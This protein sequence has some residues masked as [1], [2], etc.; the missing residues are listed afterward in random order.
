M[1][2]GKSFGRALRR[3]RAFFG[4]DRANVAMIFGLSLV[5]LTLAA[6]AGLDM[7][8]AMIVKSNLTEAV[9]AAALAVASTSTKTTMTQADMELEAKQYFWANYTLNTT[10]YGAPPIQPTVTPGTQSVTVTSTVNVPT[11]LMR[12]AKELGVTKWPYVTVNATST[13]V[14][15]QTKLWVSLVLDNTGSMTQTDGTGTSKISALQTATHQLLTMLQNASAKRRAEHECRSGIELPVDHFVQ[16][17]PLHHGRDERLVQHQHDPVQ[18]ID[19]PER[20]FDQLVH[21]SRRPLLQ[22]LLQ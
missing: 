12:I 3:L 13:V 14:W 16:R 22:W 17:L 4:N 21:W 9:D 1:S 20:A 8:R 15:G 6:G 2:M 11:T 7:T 5:P 19:L 18:R 10:A